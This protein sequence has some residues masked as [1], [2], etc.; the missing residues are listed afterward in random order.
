[1]AF[2]HNFG[3]E[4]AEKVNAFNHQNRQ[5]LSWANALANAIETY[6][7]EKKEKDAQNWE[8]EKFNIGQQNEMQR[9]ADNLGFNYA[10]LDATNQRHAD[11][12]GFNYANLDATNQRHDNMLRFNWAQ[13]KDELAYKN[14]TLPSAKIAVYLNYREKYGEKMADKLLGF[15][16]EKEKPLSEDDKKALA[17]NK[18]LPTTVNSIREAINFNEKSYDNESGLGGL[19]Q[20]GWGFVKGTPE[21]DN[22]LKAENLVKTVILPNLKTFFGNNP[23][24][25]ERAEA[26]ALGGIDPKLPKNIRRQY[27]ENLEKMLVARVTAESDARNLGAPNVP[28]SNAPQSDPQSQMS[29]TDNDAWGNL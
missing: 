23:T 5:N 4:A 22:F 28:Q 14:Q 12:L 11:D 19:I 16:D 24:E 6:G 2:G 3:L 20:N 26:L 21:R 7:N 1:M 13:H 15:K 9:H 18:M 25:G 10:N 27:L 17:G 8:Q 29:P